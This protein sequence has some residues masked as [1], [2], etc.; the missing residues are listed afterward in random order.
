MGSI[1][2]SGKSGLTRKYWYTLSVDISHIATAGT[3]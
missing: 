1:K 2:I 3:R